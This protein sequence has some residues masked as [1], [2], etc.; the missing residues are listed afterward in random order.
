MATDNEQLVLSISADTRQIQRQLKSLVG[1]TQANTKAIEDAFKGIDKASDN[2]F[3]KVAANSNRAFTTAEQGAK[4]YQNAMR[5]S[6]VQT[7]NLAAQLNDISVQLAGGQSPFL[8]ALQQGTQITQALGSGT[9]VRGAVAGVAGAFTSLLNPV[10]LATIAV[11]A[12]GGEAV[13]YFTSLLSNGEKSEETLQKQAQLIQ[14]LAKDW[15]DAV[16]ALR[17]YAD[18]LERAQKISDLQAGAQI[19]NENTLEDT[20]AAIKDVITAY[21]DFVNKL[22]NAGEESEVILHF[23]DAFNK[24]SEAARDGSLR[25]EDV[26]RVQD[27]LAAAVNSSGI[28][29]IDEF[30]DRFEKLAAAALQAASSVQQVNA[31][32][33]AATTALY[34]SQGAYAGVDRSSDGAIQNESLSLPED[35]PVPGSNPLRDESLNNDDL[36][37]KPKKATRDKAAESAKRE[38]EAVAELIEQL[39]FE[40]SLIGMT[41]AERAE[42]NALRRAGAAATDEQ[43]A[44]ISQLVEA[45][46]AE[47]DAIRANRDA[48]EELQD[49]S[50]DVLGGIISDL[51]EGKSGA[52]ILAGALER[53]ASRLF[54]AGLNGLFPSTGAGGT[55]KG[56]FGGAIIPGILHNGGIAGSDGYGHGRA[57]SPSV[58]KGAK[59]Y[60][61]GGIAGL[62][63]NEVPAILERG[64]RITRKGDSGSNGSVS[65]NYSPSYD[66]RGVD[67]E[68]LARLEQLQ[69]KDRREFSSRAISAVQKARKSNV[70]GL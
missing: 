15:G 64:E 39:E 23:Q 32:T 11:I 53:V 9:G 46:Y 25:V 28:P 42:A 24:F 16:P 43:K 3:G 7:G 52:D 19:I 66:N 57:F 49:V 38:K 47:R 68:R 55:G 14:Q 35:G 20:N 61:N 67:G 34:P 54:D 22:Q 29:A 33:G 10:S 21:D 48:M 65:I 37:G 13:Q 62:R 51:R 45:S 5:S 6:T 30:R 60:H 26:Q 31:Q 59:R 58:F 56:I 44:K 40:Q 41:S 1:Q 12:L 8:I 2:A 36:Y 63:P 4:R 50:R 18:E 17:E 27:A 70:K 69:E